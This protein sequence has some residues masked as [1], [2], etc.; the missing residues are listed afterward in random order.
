MEV[1]A[2]SLSSKSRVADIK[3][4]GNVAY[5]LFGS[6]DKIEMALLSTKIE[7]RKLTI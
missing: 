5:F 2:N 6:T 1:F 7:Y 3:T 4:K